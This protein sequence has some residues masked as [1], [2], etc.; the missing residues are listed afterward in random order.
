MIS[1]GSVISEEGTSVKTEE[2][3]NTNGTLEYSSKDTFFFGRVLSFKTDWNLQP[4]ESKISIN[5]GAQAHKSS[6]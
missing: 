1:T 5:V 3:Y 2:G 4:R 6:S